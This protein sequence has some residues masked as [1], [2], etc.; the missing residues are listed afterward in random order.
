VARNLRELGLVVDADDVVTSAQAAAALI[1]DRVPAAARVLAVGGPGVPAALEAVGLTVVRPHELTEAAS[2]AASEAATDSA[3]SG[4]EV[5]AVLMGYGPDVGWKDLAEAAYAVGDGAVFVASNTD[6]TVPTDRGVAPGNGALVAAVATATGR[7][8][9]VAGKP[10]SPLLQKSIERTGARTPL[11]VGD[12]LDTDIEA[13]T[14]LGLPSLLVLTGVTDVPG[15]L[16]ATVAHRP[17]YVA[18]D[19]RGLLARGRL[20]CASP[21]AQLSEDGALQLSELDDSTAAADPLLRLRAAAA[22]CWAAA[23][24]GRAVT[25][26]EAA[27]AALA[28]DVDRALSGGSGH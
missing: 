4:S 24:Q 5:A 9:I 14:R 23:D 20:V 17:T 8:P 28:A 3:D 21:A 7:N 15:L 19:L 18:A 16:A 1:L 27:V 12:R 2:K 25:W 22:A 26:S 11:V 13:A 10:F 6:L